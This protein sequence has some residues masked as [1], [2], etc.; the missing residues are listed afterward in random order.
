MRIDSNM[1]KLKLKPARD[2]IK[3][4]GALSLVEYHQTAASQQLHHIL[5]SFHS[6]LFLFISL[7][8][9]R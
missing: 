9:A 5:L 1:E 4:S 7:I 6:R 2:E 3:N 8:A